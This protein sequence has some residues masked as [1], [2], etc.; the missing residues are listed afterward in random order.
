M[1]NS[2][3]T[4]SNAY[5]LEVRG[6]TKRFGPVT[7]VDHVDLPVERGTVH[8][9]VGENGAGKTTLMKCI[10]GLIKPD[11]GEILVG[12]EPADVN[13]VR[14]ALDLGIGMVHQ[15]F[16]VVGDLSLAE[17]LVLG[18]EPARRGVL[19]RRA[20][21][22][23]T[24]RL[25][26]QTG[27]R[28][29][30]SQQAD[31]VGVADLQRLELLRQLH[32]GADLLILDEPT[33]V[34]GPAEI[35]LLLETVKDLRNRGT[36]I[37]FISHKLDEVMRISDHITVL[38]GG[39]RVQTTACA[40]TSPADLARA[41]VGESLR[42]PDVDDRPPSG[43]EPVLQVEGLTVVD[44]QGVTRVDTVGLTVQGGEIVG[45]YGVAGSGQAHL[46]AALTGLVRSSGSIRLKGEELNRRTVGQRRR[47]GMAFVSP[48]RRGE[49]L[50]LTESVEDN[51]LAGAH[52]HPEVSGKLVKRSSKWRERVSQLIDRYSIRVGSADD[53]AASLS[54]GN[55]QRLVVGRE[56]DM[57][58]SLLVASD[59]TRGVDI[60]GVAGIHEL[61]MGIR[62]LGG[63]VLLV[64]HDLD[65]VLALADRIAVI[66]DGRIT[67]ILNRGEATR[68]TVAERMTVGGER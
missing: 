46:V 41:M 14:D 67:A 45:V 55:Q 3:S 6:L 7:A 56:L 21:T 44:E 5:R 31:R 9:I 33:A 2:A 4:R 40:D 26:D 29:P 65:E 39:Q 48:D 53:P 42:S 63:S 62:R 58:P 25:A 30:W 59:P 15:E 23:A 16:S 51:A 8:S 24:E 32:R 11:S 34:L 35:D 66:F 57:R 12:G 68:T 60:E 61:L 13:S 64:S 22:E 50:A 10:A 37:L 54:G 1:T 47:T 17:N 19:D 43:S 20:V 28:L 38:R 52:R 36:T 18:V 27:W 49:G